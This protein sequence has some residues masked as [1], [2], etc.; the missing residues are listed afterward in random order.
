[1]KKYSIFV[2]ILVLTTLALA[3]CRNPNGPMDSTTVPTT[4]VTSAP[5]TMPTE[6]ATSPSRNTE[7]PTEVP[8]YTTPSGSTMPDSTDAT[9]STNGSNSTTPTGESRARTMPGRR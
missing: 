8:E 7:M 3:G 5:T 1:M 2:L 4:N 6:A 9:D